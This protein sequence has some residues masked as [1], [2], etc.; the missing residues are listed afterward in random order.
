MDH[1]GVGDERD[2][3]DRVEAVPRIGVAVPS[4]ASADV[5]QDIEH[6]QH[7][8][9]RVRGARLDEPG[10]HLRVRVDRIAALVDEDLQLHARHGRLD[11]GIRQ[12]P[13]ALRRDLRAGSSL[14]SV[15]R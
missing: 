3:V 13:S 4:I 9:G 2:V 15:C 11:A 12:R 5:D 6:R 1:L 8:G 14:R 10:D 7:L